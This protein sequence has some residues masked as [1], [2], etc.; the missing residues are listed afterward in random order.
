MR[1]LVVLLAFGVIVPS[2]T[3][4]L[5]G[6]ESSAPTEQYAAPTKTAAL[7]QEAAATTPY[8]ANPSPMPSPVPA[9][10][11][12]LEFAPADSPETSG[13]D[14]GITEVEQEASQKSGP[15]AG[16]VQGQTYTWEDGDGT[17]TVYL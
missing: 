1:K 10:D 2:V 12:E 7:L 6:C 9:A 8:A 5:A 4:V 14:G 16:P 13:K 15:V 17:L 3:A 11:D